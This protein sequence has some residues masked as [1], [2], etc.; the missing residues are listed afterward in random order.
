MQNWLKNGDCRINKTTSA[1]GHLVKHY[2]LNNERLSMTIMDRRMQQKRSDVKA[3]GRLR[4]SYL[5]R[6][7]RV[8]YLT[9][10]KPSVNQFNF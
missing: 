10:P 8:H 4:K 2:L 5:R 9:S 1:S 6:S 3:A 7:C